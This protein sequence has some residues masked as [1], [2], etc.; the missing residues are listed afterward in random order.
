M[1]AFKFRTKYD[2]SRPNCRPWLYGIA[3]NIVGDEIRRTRRSERIFLAV[4]GLRVGE[5]D[6]YELATDRV[7]AQ[8]VQLTLNSGLARLANGD[9]NVLLLYAVE[10][11]SYQEIADALQIP[12]G[13]VRS[14]LARAR[15]KLRQHAPQLEQELDHVLRS[16]KADES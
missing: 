1:R 6:E 7:S 13:T 2:G 10:Q 8:N 14:R 4:A 15:R 11:L 3:T 5:R 16:Q 12:I 9:R